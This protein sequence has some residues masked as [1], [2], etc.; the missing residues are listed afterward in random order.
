MEQSAA[1]YGQPLN[2]PEIHQFLDHVLGIDHNDPVH[3]DLIRPVCIWG[4]AGIG[5]TQLVRDYAEQ[6]GMAFG[7]VAPAQ[8]EEMGDF[9]GMP[10]VSGDR[11]RYAVPQWVPQDTGQPGILLLDDFNRSDERILK[12]LMQLFQNHSLM[13]WSL[14]QHWHILCTANPDQTDYA[15]TR[16]DEAMLT[17]LLHVT[18]RFDPKAWAEWALANRI[19]SRGIDFILTYPEMAEGRMTN[20][21]SLSTFFRHTALIGDILG[22]QA[23]VKAI[24]ASLLDTETVST[25]LSFVQEAL[26]H[27]PTTEEILLA[28]D[29]K[30]VEQRLYKLCVRPDTIRLD[31]LGT[32]TTRLMMQ[33]R[34][35]PPAEPSVENLLRFL[36][37][38]FLP[39]D[40]RASMHREIVAMARP[41]FN[42]ILQDKKLASLIV[43]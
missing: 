9:H 14:P 23:L 11:M 32:V 40:L 13:S 42:K 19:D 8:F 20:P 1:G 28:T 30:S 22:Q 41:A 10:V 35:K 17:R 38:G 29:F 12:G 6:K 27:L 7:Y 25:F 18:L 31:I 33:I 39:N 24:A 26:Q 15:V 36:K 4:R 16:L 37:L 43:G 21:R 34:L 2:V 3:R 5:K